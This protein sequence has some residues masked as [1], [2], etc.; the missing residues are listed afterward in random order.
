M[1]I[2]YTIKG[3]IKA[4]VWQTL[5]RPR[6]GSGLQSWCLRC[7][8]FNKSINQSTKAQQPQLELEKFETQFNIIWQ[9]C[10]QNDRSRIWAIWPY[11]NYNTYSFPCRSRQKAGFAGPRERAMLTRRW[12][13]A[14]PVTRTRRLMKRPTAKTWLRPYEAWQPNVTSWPQ[15]CL[16]L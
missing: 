10:R 14:S 15:W 13:S 2:L 6:S 1:R 7:Q 12:E 8:L 9:A 16:Y 4:I 5:D 3:T 11:I